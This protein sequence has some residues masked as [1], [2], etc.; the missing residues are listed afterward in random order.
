[1]TSP[2]HV[3]NVLVMNRRHVWLLLSVGLLTGCAT[4]QPQPR[5]HLP[6]PVPKFAVELPS[7]NGFPPRYVM[8]SDRGEVSWLLHCENHPECALELKYAIRGDSLVIT[9]AICLDKPPCEHLGEYSGRM[10]DSVTLSGMRQF[11]LE[12]VTLK[13]VSPEPDSSVP[14]PKAVSKV[15]SIQIDIVG[16]DRNSYTVAM[17]NL[18]AMAVTEVAFP[19]RTSGGEKEDLIAPGATYRHR[20]PVPDGWMV[21]N[22]VFVEDPPPPF[23]VLEAAFFK[24]GSYEG[25]P[26]TRP[27]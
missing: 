10:G 15:P 2:R 16:E 18:S 27:L 23:I 9:A 8:I 3:T 17:H 26:D 24:D 7:S 21:S 20:I 6:E 1:V 5:E 13:I 25:D 12:P 22:G 4:A 19:G 14:R 11:G